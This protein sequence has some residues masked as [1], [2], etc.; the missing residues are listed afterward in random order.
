M[1]R[2][3]F[4]SS[5]IYA[6][7]ILLTSTSMNSFNCFSLHLK[8][9]NLTLQKWNKCPNCRKKK[10]KLLACT[11]SFVIKLLLLSNWVL[12]YS[13]YDYFYVH[14]WYMKEKVLELY[15]FEYSRII[16][17]DIYIS[18]KHLQKLLMSK[19]LYWEKFIYHILQS[20]IFSND[21]I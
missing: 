9:I 12:L 15:Y 3:T 13:N 1:S 10:R 4:Q 8:E 21:N 2:N 5:I 7:C 18:I 17:S 16:F 11:T 14:R 6:I 20:K 19:E